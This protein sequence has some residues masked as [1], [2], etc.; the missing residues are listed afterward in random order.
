LEP[1]DNHLCDL[2]LKV[3]NERLH[4]EAGG[5]WRQAGA[6]IKQRGNYAR[7]FPAFIECQ[8]EALRKYLELRSVRH[9]GRDS[10]DFAAKG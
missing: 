7:F 6:E 10:R 3:A 4:A 2:K 9:F 5:C 1:F 8:L